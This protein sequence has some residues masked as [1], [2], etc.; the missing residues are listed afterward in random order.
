MNKK[1]LHQIIQLGEGF[2][3]EFKKSFSSGIGKEICAFANSIG[4]KIFVGVDDNGKNLNCLK[5]PFVKHF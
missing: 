5:K 3:A 1:E 4:G 2:N